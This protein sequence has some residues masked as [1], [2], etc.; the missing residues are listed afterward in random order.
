[1][2]NQNE[3]SDYSQNKEQANQV[4][5]SRHPSN[6]TEPTRRIG[7]A[8]MGVT[9]VV[10][11]VLLICFFFKPF[12]LFSLMKFSPILLILLG[13]ETL[14]QYFRHKGEN[15]RYDFMGT[16]FSLT[17]IL[18]AGCFSVFYPLYMTYG[19]A[20][21]KVEEQVCGEIENEIYQQLPE[22]IPVASLNVECDISSVSPSTQSI[23]INELTSGDSVTLYFTLKQQE[24]LSS[25][26][27]NVRTL[28]DNLSN[29]SYP[30]LSVYVEALCPEG[31]YSI[32]LYDRFA[33]RYSV[34]EIQQATE[35]DRY[36][37]EELESE[38]ALTLGS[39]TENV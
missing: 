18:I 3:N 31:D 32:W 35:I 20:N 16:F 27:Q 37:S 39:S 7:T 24:N 29:V 8:T 33:M 38:E 13:I 26:S 25:F 17:V 21:W 9:L 15:L 19:P 2:L 10:C 4:P 22:N 34:Q 23:S 1:M 36:Y 30:N 28:L 12:D 14:W 6:R 5:H 11:G